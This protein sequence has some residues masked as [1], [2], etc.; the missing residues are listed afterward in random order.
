MDHL[1]RR[2]IELI[3]LLLAA[4]PV[5]VLFAM[6]AYVRGDALEPGAWIVPA[7]LLAGFGVAHVAVRKWAPAADPA[8]LPIAFVL[9]GVGIVFVTRLAPAAATKQV[10]WL[11]LGLAACIAMLA[12]VRRAEN[13]T[14]YKYTFGLAAVLLLLSP[15]LPYIGTEINGSRIWLTAGPLSFQPGELA[16]VALIIFL[17]G[18]LAQNRTTLSVF[19]GRIGPIRVPDI[20]TLLPMLVMWGLA[21]VVVIFEKDLGSALMFFCVFLVMLYVASGRKMYLII[22][23][24][25]AAAAAVFLYGFFGHVQVRVATWLN[26]FDDPLDSGYQLCQT[27]YSLA[28]GGMLGAGI[29]AGL[30]D[31]IPVVESDFI[32]AAI[33]EETGLL[34]SG[35]V[36]L[37]YVALAVRGMVT[38]ARARTDVAALM[39]V[40]FT[41]VIVLQAFIIVGGV[42]RLV[43]L[44]GITLPFISQGGSSLV[45]NFIAV[46]LMLV[47]GSDGA[48]LGEEVAN[49]TGTRG[50]VRNPFA[51]N[52][53]EQ[54]PLG[55]VALGRRLTGTLIVFGVLYAL[56]LANLT[57]IMTVRADAIHEMPYNNHT[58]LNAQRIRR[59][60]IVTSDGVVLATSVR[61]EDGTYTRV[62]P[63]GTAAAHVVGYYSLR[64]GTAGLES[65]ANVDLTGSAGY[66]SWSQAL[67][68]LAGSGTA[69][70]T[71]TLT[72][73]SSVQEAAQ[74]ALG[75]YAGACVVM[76]T[77]GAILGMASAPTFDPG[78]VATILDNPEAYANSPLF[79]RAIQAAYAPGSTFKLITLA[80]V[81]ETGLFT[82][83]DEFEAPA[84]LEVGGADVVNF[85]NE[86]YGTVTLARAT[87]LSANTVY[88]QLAV[89]MGP[90]T[91][92]AGAD[93][94][95]FDTE[96]PFELDVATS[97][98]PDPDEMTLWETA[99]AAA[100]EPVGSHPS[101]AGPQVTVLEVALYGCAFVN[102]GAIPAPYLIDHITDADGTV[103]QE[104]IP[105]TLRQAV[106]PATAARVKTIMEG[107][108]KHGTA[109]MADIPG[110][111]VGAKT[112]TAEKNAETADGWF[113]GFAELPDGYTVVVAIVLEDSGSGVAAGRAHDV[114]LAA[115][116]AHGF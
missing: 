3:L 96:L 53:V 86:D 107:V 113:V 50:G 60:D 17:A 10:I 103:I 56:L 34:G 9:S 47:C 13:L 44:T 114:L 85:N 67:A 32:F 36:L 80:T 91:L 58:V 41:A 108:V 84:R 100:G 21:L 106:S 25:L 61:N 52:A 43:P 81:L 92:V 11:A 4:C 28:D 19:T 22:A 55:R 115:L 63:Q 33:A 45:A 95:L 6:L 104:A 102:G 37:L 101:P 35:C 82:E 89:A 39:S 48:G 76:T 87:E 62:Y 68:T 59:G 26:P 69:G 7:G 42:T 88:A 49:G 54:G 15:L 40:G 57:S 109:W 99:W 16:K 23:G 79:N 97:L 94:F 30:C 27:F 78:D 90:R 18:Y 64:Y 70:N 93:A 12:F 66:T 77:D 83:T 20:A 8:I 65:A 5:L 14:A 112:G 110:A 38:A 74:A 98:M 46:G 75:E 73:D 29:G 105:Y 24:I 71:L 51:D 1:N 111:V 72:L 2:T 116:R 31:L